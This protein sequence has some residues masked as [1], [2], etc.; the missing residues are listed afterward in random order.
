MHEKVSCEH[1]SEECRIGEGKCFTGNVGGEV[2]CMGALKMAG[3]RLSAHR[4]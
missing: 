4:E 3:K 2:E 1:W